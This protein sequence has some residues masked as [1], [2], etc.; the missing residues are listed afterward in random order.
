MVKSP[1]FFIKRIEFVEDYADFGP[2][3]FRI[4][5][6]S[7]AHTRIVGAAILD[8]EQKSPGDAKRFPRD[9]DVRLQHTQSLLRL[10]DSSTPIR[11]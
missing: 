6:H 1:S 4:R 10:A 7:S 8:V 3:T 11:A 9:A 5:L 2:F